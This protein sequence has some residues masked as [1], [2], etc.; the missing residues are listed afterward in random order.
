[1]KKSKI[2]GWKNVFSFTFTQTAKSRSFVASTFVLGLI[3]FLVMA[4]VHVSSSYSGR[5]SKQEAVKQETADKKENSKKQFAHTVYMKDETGLALSMQEIGDYINK[6]YDSVNFVEA[7][8]DHSEMIEEMK[9]A[10]ADSAYLHL[11]FDES[12]I[13]VDVYLPEN[14]TYEEEQ[15]DKFATRVANYVEKWKDT[16][17]ALNDEQK[18]FL[19]ADITT[20][21]TTQNSKSLVEKLVDMYVP[22]M[23]CFVLYMCIILYGQMVGTSVATEKSSK[24]MELLLTSVR[25]LAVIVGKVLSMMALALVQLVIFVVLLLAGN[26]VGYMLARNIDP[27]YSSVVIDLLHEFNLLS[28]FSPVRILFAFLVFILGFTFYCTLAGLMGATVNRGEDLS[29]AMTVYS[30]VSVI[31]FML[32]Y[33]PSMLGDSGKGIQTF[34][35]IFPLSSPF[36]LPAKILTGELSAGMIAAGIAVLA[37]MVA[38]FL[39]IVA[40][41]YEMVILYSGNKIGI[42]EIRKML[43]SNHVEA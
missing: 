30:T 12:G 16:Y 21:V 5:D 25:P 9:M 14:T 38:V 15:A 1:M 6:K 7:E 8:K 39:M 28:M 43:H 17:L 31:G 36:I 23:M 11:G 18:A 42:K 41:V 40:K 13:A 22:M 2:T 24:V 4:G 10:D 26:E 34:A 3:F 19:A 27:E 29:S 20:S 35:T 32:A 33:L 37:L